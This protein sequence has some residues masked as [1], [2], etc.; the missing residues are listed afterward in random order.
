MP[1]RA[2]SVPLG[3]LP[4]PP[5]TASLHTSLQVDARLAQ[6]SHDRRVRF[7]PSIAHQK[8][9]GRRPV[10]ELQIVHSQRET[11]PQPSPGQPGTSPRPRLVGCHGRRPARVELASGREVNQPPRS[12]APVDGP[13]GV[14]AD[15]D[16]EGN[17][18]VVP[19]VAAERHRGS[20]P[21]RGAGGWSAAQEG[22]AGPEVP[23]D[24]A[25]PEDCGGVL[26]LR[27]EGPATPIT[28]PRIDRPRDRTP[29]RSAA[30]VS[31]RTPRA[32][33]SSMPPPSASCTVE[34]VDQVE[35]PSARSVAA[36]STAARWP[37]RLTMPLASTSPD[38][39]MPKAVVTWASAGLASLRR[40]WIAATSTTIAT[41][42]T[43][44]I[45]RY[46]CRPATPRRV[47]TRSSHQA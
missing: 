41:P 1:L 27:D 35:T 46:S 20:L 4:C 47:A 19:E 24:E 5:L 42:A 2:T 43:R 34:T 40:S 10:P 7:D 9:A 14:E 21:D 45:S 8:T 15:S 30:T 17:D 3:V 33:T 11:T 31:S 13:E 39:I 22:A 32:P 12:L 37:T 44:S 25:D 23:T 28:M 36:S 18:S 26:D 16:D 29:V 6:I 38:Q